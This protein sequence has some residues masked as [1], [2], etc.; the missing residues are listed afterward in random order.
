MLLKV[1]MLSSTTS[2]TKSNIC[3][4]P[5]EIAF[6]LLVFLHNFLHVHQNS[7]LSFGYNFLSSFRYVRITILCDMIL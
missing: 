5:I 4:V 1:K 2:H 7:E 6:F 3:P